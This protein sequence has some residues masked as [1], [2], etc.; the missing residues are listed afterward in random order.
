MRRCR[1]SRIER[2]TKAKRN[3]TRRTRD[4]DDDDLLLVPVFFRRD[5]HLHSPRRV[6]D[7]ARRGTFCLFLLRK[8]KKKKKKKNTLCIAFSLRE[9]MY[10]K[11]TL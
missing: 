10:D 8:K 11:R 6:D 2:H 9:S 3:K 5:W 1:E 4:D 7:H